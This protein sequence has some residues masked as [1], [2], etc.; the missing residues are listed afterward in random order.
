MPE[1]S[2]NT[3]SLGLMTL[4]PRTQCYETTIDGP[5][6]NP[7][8]FSIYVS[9]IDELQRLDAFAEWFQ[10]N[11]VAF[12]KPLEYEIQN[13]D[14]VWDDVWDEILGNDWT[15][16]RD[17]FLAKHL[18]YRSVDISSG[19]LCVWV[20]TGRLHTDHMVRVTINGKMEIE[21]CEML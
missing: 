9:D 19:K 12:K 21:C 1:P 2:V 17:G 20:D 18:T 3:S 7:I 6:E 14:L 13:Y 5:Y 16:Q 15:E 4:D 8:R 11:H 10:V